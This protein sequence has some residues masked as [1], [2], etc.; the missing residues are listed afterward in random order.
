MWNFVRL[1]LLVCCLLNVDYA[2]FAEESG[3]GKVKPVFEDGLFKCS[4]GYDP[5]T[6]ASLHPPGQ[7]PRTRQLVNAQA[8]AS[9]EKKVEAEK[10]AES[11]KGKESGGGSDKI[12]AIGSKDDKEDKKDEK[13]KDKDKDKDKDEKDKDEKDKD[14]DKDKKDDKETAEKKDDKKEDK[15][16]DKETAEKKDNKKDDKKDVKETAEKKDDKKDGKKDEKAEEKAEEKSKPASGTLDLA[17]AS[18]PMN[19]ALYAIQNKHYQEGA[20]LLNGVL[21]TNSKDAQAHYLLAVSY[22]GLRRYGDAKEQ[23]HLVLQ[24]AA[25]PK[26][27]D[28]A[29]S[30]LQRISGSSATP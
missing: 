3:E 18:T 27:I 17:K 1:G 24:S 8:Q 2:V 12:E 10:A 22:V 13:E 5:D 29:K 20:D 6:D 11:G 16:D 23:Y 19:R 15:N 9:H 14:K 7:D 4:D 25:N 21:K 30:G 26:L 28:M